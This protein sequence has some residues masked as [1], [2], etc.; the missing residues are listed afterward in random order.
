M[1][2]SWSHLQDSVLK[3]NLEYM[4]TKCNLKKTTN[5]HNSTYAINVQHDACLELKLIKGR[6]K[7]TSVWYEEMGLGWGWGVEALSGELELRRKVM[8]CCETER[9][10][11]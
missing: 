7:R 5:T 1:L 3:R 6:E 4:I 10:V 8:G 11:S 2:N 9:G